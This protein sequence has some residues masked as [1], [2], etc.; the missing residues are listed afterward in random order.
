MIPSKIFSS[1]IAQ[2]LISP[3]VIMSEN[4]WQRLFFF[5]FRTF[6][7]FAL[8]HFIKL[9]TILSS[10]C[11][12]AFIL[13]FQLLLFVHPSPDPQASPNPCRARFVNPCVESTYLCQGQTARFVSLPTLFFNPL[14]QNGLIRTESHPAEIPFRTPITNFVKHPRFLPPKIENFFT[15]VQNGCISGGIGVHF[16][17]FQGQNDKKSAHFPPPV[18]RV[19]YFVSSGLSGRY[20]GIFTEIPILRIS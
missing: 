13:G 7:T 2:I 6:H 8:S 10:P 14:S 20:S 5:S 17:A 11:P 4:S 19:P 15:P 9:A 16:G 3:F 1:S 18:F 12:S